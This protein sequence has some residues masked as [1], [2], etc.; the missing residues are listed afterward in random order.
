RCRR[1]FKPHF[2]EPFRSG[3][4]QISQADWARAQVR[5]FKARK[6][7]AVA[8]LR[9]ERGG[10]GRRWRVEPAKCQKPDEKAADMGLPGDRRI[11]DPERHRG[12]AKQ[13][14]GEEPE[15]KKTDRAAIGQNFPQRQRRLAI[16]H[17]L[18]RAFREA[19][20]FAK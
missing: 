2:D 19:E 15:E 20:R 8:R 9:L 6:E 17:A 4:S 10:E 16:S 11:G 18:V 14:I 13:K 5:R 7:P 12:G 3:G 1:F